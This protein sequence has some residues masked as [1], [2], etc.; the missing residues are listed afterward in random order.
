MFSGGLPTTSVVSARGQ[1]DFVHEGAPENITAV[2]QKDL[3]QLR[4]QV[5]RCGTGGLAAMEPQASLCEVA[6]P[7]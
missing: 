2:L 3:A 1:Q 7:C 5:L 4:R 6:I